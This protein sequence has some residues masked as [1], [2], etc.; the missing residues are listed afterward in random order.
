MHLNKS[1][2]REYDIRGI[3]KTDF[4]DSVVESLGK[5]FGTY[6]LKQNGNTISVSGDIRESSP[7]L[8]QNFINGV[9]STGANVIDVGILPTPVNYYSIYHLDVDAAVQITGSHNPNEFNG[10]KFSCKKESFYGEKIQ[11]LKN[12][13]LNKNYTSGN[14]TLKKQNILNNYIEMLCSKIKLNKKLKVIIDSGNACGCLTVP[15][16]L[17][18]LGVNVEELYCNI[19]SSFPNHHPDPTVD[20]NLKDII[21]KIKE[22][23][24][25]LGMAFDG[26]ADRIV[27]IDENGEIIRSDNLICLFLPEIITSTNKKII[28]DVK[29]SESLEKMI[30]KYGGTPL[31]WKTGHSLIKDKMKIEKANFAGEMSGHIFFGDDYYGY[32]DALYVGLRLLQ[33]LSNTN[34]K[35][36]QLT[37]EIPKYYSTPEMRIDCVND[38]EKFKITE[39]AIQ[40]FTN[41]YECITI[42]GVRIKFKNGWG[43][44][45]SSNTQPV[46]VCR[47][48][49]TTQNDLNQ[50]KDMVLNKLNE[51]GE[52]KYHE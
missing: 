20:S 4:P 36:S 16:T 24:F 34:K 50:M 35:L 19:D 49:A 14:G 39:K 23:D 22:S 10:F 9:L 48:E 52:I 45:R 15:Q 18:K 30:I 41:N 6:I 21:S 51:F 28:F 7:I 32:D 12:M 2:F 13:I 5:A 44:V 3:V 46:I 26:D 33:I 11:Q 43:L 40:Y 47:F 27:V 42:D 8:K 29:C 31:M 17:K 38:E 37:N 1:I 25:D